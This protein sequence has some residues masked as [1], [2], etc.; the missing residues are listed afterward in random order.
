MNAALS[1]V[2]GLGEWLATGPL[3]G[4]LLG[5]RV[6]PALEG[7]LSVG[8]ERRPRFL[9]DGLAYHRRPL[10]RLSRRPL[11]A[12]IE[13]H[14]AE[15]AGTHLDLRIKLPDGTI[16]D[17]AV[18]KASELPTATGKVVKVIPTPNHSR[19]YFAQDGKWTFAEGYGKG[20][21]ETVWRGQIDVREANPGKIEFAIPDGKFAGEFFIR[22]L[23]EGW[24]LGRMKEPAGAER[25][26][27][28]EPFANTE[29]ARERMYA[30]PEGIVAEVKENGAHYELIPG[31]KENVLLSR[32][33][34]VEGK[35]VDRRHY[36]PQLRD[37][38]FPKKYLGRRIHVEVISGADDLETSPSTTAG[39][40]NAHVALSRANQ[41]R[42]GK[43]LRA[44]AFNLDGSGTYLERKAELRKLAAASPRIDLRNQGV[45]AHRFM[46]V[47]L[48]QPRVIDVVLDNL[49]TGEDP[50]SFV[51]RLKAEGYEGGVLKRRD[52]AYRD[53]CP[54]KDKAHLDDLDLVAVGFEEGRGK[55]AG[56]LGALV[57]EDPATGVRT[58]VGTGFSDF[59]RWWIWE[60]QELVRGR[61]VKVQANWRI[62]ATGNLHG[63]RWRGFHPESG[64]V[65]DD[66]QGLLD[67]AEASSEE[68]RMMETKYKMISSRGWRAGR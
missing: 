36:L 64:V 29:A 67:Y 8:Y 27:E 37:M 48:R 56:E 34:S 45:V 63:P 19:R 55:F 44:V 5:A 11:E 65:L 66:E 23:S 25:W 24:V 15:R 22:R 40:L 43:P 7:H 32:R 57:C 13:L 1:V 31:P 53:E 12:K 6:R 54:T 49:Q 17:F 2:A 14:E 9:A 58:K 59:E 4:P 61:T 47:R 39:L 18:A 68:G 3:F 20:K 21:V 46:S 62:A 28:R 16:Q 51:E 38:R 10:P 42:L 30:D 52:A 41:T 50:R 35:V 60:N 26:I 33:L